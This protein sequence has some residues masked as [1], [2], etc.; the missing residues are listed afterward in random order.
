[1]KLYIRAVTIEELEQQYG[2]DPGMTKKKF[3]E[4][5]NLDPTADYGR[6]TP[7]ANKRGKYGPWIMKQYRLGN[8]TE[9]DYDNIRD[10]LDLFSKDYRHFPKSDL[11]QYKT[12]TEFLSDANRVGNRELTAKELE[13]LH[14]K[15]AHS[16]GDSDKK[17][18]CEDG[19][20]ELWTP[21]TYQGSIA[22]ARSGGGPQ[23]EWCTAWTRSDT[24]YK[25]YTA[26]GPLY[27][28]LNK[29]NTGEKYQTH[30]GSDG[31]N[32]WFYDARDYEQG[33]RAFFAFL[34]KHPT[35]K[36]FF[37]VRD[38]NGVR[39]M[40]E[41]IIGYTPDAT[42]IIIPDGVTMIPNKQFPN[43]CTRV[44]LPDSVTTISDNAFK[45]SNVETVEFDAVT[46]IG[47][48]AFE[49]SA[50][51]DIDLSGVELIDNGAFRNC[52][53]LTSVNYSD[54]VKLG[55]YAFAGCTGLRGP[56]VQPKTA[57]ISSGTFNG[58]SNLTLIW[59]DDD[60]AY[61]LDDIKLLKVD[62]ATHPQLVATNENYVTIQDL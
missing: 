4:L 55:A 60:A 59:E 9:T 45:N 29:N 17:F 20:W 42:E 8:I 24:H 35:F 6:T 37:R 16:A 11:N 56:I 43:S 31:R 38:T 48:C 13:K 32:S 2:K 1:M 14:G 30:I 10:A 54:Y 52:T 62:V 57:L 49:G 3:K 36:E 44:V 28:F 19:D 34:D 46:T 5:I 41:T 40:A 18:L 12:V 33:E 22:L 27:I 23:A 26:R 21:L 51:R 25:S 58:C 53:N 15:Q 47:K 50:I 39:T 7:T 61:P